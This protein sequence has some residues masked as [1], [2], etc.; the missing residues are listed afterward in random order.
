MNK[1]VT[2]E[3]AKKKILRYCA[4]QERSH[5]EV[6]N[7]LYSFG[8]F[9]SDVNEIISYLITEGFLNEERFAR[10]FAGGKF[11]MKSWGRLRIVRELEAR[12]L[13]RNCINLGL[14]EI[15][16]EEYQTSL[17]RLLEK[18][19]NQLR[20]ENLFVKRDKLATYAI[21]KGFEPERVWKTIKQLFPD[22]S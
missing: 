15:G 14:K 4:Y 11:R 22:Q 10:A 9:S 6:K 7:K 8:L 5:L 17:V 20:E 13:T 18:K 21:W 2:P 12:G 3:E 19:Y 16:Q 1:Q